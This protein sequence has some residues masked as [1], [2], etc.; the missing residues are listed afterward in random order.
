MLLA[1]VVVALVCVLLVWVVVVLVWLVVELLVTV[2]A[3]GV[4][5]TDAGAVA[6]AV[7]SAGWLM[8]MDAPRLR[9][10]STISARVGMMAVST[11]T[12]GTGPGGAGSTEV[13]VTVAV[14]WVVALDSAGESDR[15][16]SDVDPSSSDSAE[17]LEAVTPPGIALPGAKANVPEPASKCRL[18]RFTWRF[19]PFDRE[20]TVKVL[21]PAVM[22][23]GLAPPDKVV[24]VIPKGPETFN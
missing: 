5:L 18:P 1:S 16:W 14:V 21:E 17:G 2:L 3:A 9:L 13:W 20:L 15:I 8:E 12:A 6:N 22:L 23:P 7:V 19:E 11:L 10:V 4:V 24:A